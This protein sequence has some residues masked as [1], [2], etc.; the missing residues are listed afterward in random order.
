[1]SAK[2]LTD[3]ERLDQ[4]EAAIVM[5]AQQG[6]TVATPPPGTVL[7]EIWKRLEA[8]EKD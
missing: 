4:I 8:A 2:K 7:E 1:M 3:S 5:V 6:T